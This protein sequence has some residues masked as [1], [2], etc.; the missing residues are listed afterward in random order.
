M[1]DLTTATPTMTLAERDQQVVWHPFTQM[2]TAGLP[3]PIV[4]GEGVYL[5]DEE[6]NQYIDAIAS[7]WMNLHGHAHPYIAKKLSEQALQLEH[8]IF[9]NFTHKPAVELAERVL[10]KLPENQKRFFFSDNGSTAVEVALKMCFQ[11]WHNID[12][13]K[14]KIIAFN[15]AYHGD[16][17]GAM[18]VS[19]RSAFSAPF[20]PFLFDVTFVD[21]PTADKADEVL[22]Q[23]TELVKQGDVAG[24]IYEPLLQ[25]S[26]GM[27]MYAPEALEPLLKVCKD[28]DVLC[29][30]DEVMVGFGRTGTFFASEQMTTKPDIFALSKGLT[31]GT[32]A[33]GATT[34]TQQIFDAFWSNDK[35][36]TLFHGHSCTGNPLACAVG[37]A[38]MDL[39]EKPETQASMK[40]IIQRHKQFQEVLQTY[41]IA[42][43]I[44]QHGVV[45]AFDIV[46]GE[47]TSYFNSIRDEIWNFFISRYL[48]LRPLGNTV[49]I[50]PPYV[51]N[52]AQLDL[53]YE[54]IEDLLKHF[55]NKK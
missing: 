55:S 16:T 24:F 33:L 22:K 1:T 53:V 34:C 11:Y 46:T 5:Y 42:H 41:P 18:A 49:Y 15:D 38:S 3:T 45:L 32:M 13:P 51:I 39:M 27:V 10:A 23:V 35:F 37:L 36:K 52:D 7:W 21:A 43:N 44:R 25:G 12:Q 47:E 14:T 48:L 8:V 28:N 29:I 4:K 26:A 6:G 50:L 17:F 54:G 20:A 31:G 9:A 19:G 30:A 40:N 2:K